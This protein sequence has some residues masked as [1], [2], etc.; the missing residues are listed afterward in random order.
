LLDA[1]LSLVPLE[2]RPVVCKSANARTRATLIF[3]VGIDGRAL[4]ITV[5]SL[6]SIFQVTQFP[7]IVNSLLHEIWDPMLSEEYRAEQRRKL[8]EFLVNYEAPV[9]MFQ[10]VQFDNHTL[11]YPFG[12]PPNPLR[13]PDLLDVIALFEPKY[14]V[15]IIV[16]LQSLEEG[17]RYALDRFPS[18]CESLRNTSEALFPRD[19]DGCNDINYR[20]RTAEDGMA[21]LTGQLQLLSREYYRVLWYDDMTGHWPDM[22]KPLQAYLK[23]MRWNAMRVMKRIKRLKVNLAQLTQGQKLF[24][25]KMVG[26]IK[27]AQ[28][29]PILQNEFDLIRFV[30]SDRS[31]AEE[32]ICV[33]G[34]LPSENFPHFQGLQH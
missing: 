29:A 15:K 33:T 5:K 19:G 20:A 25:F 3:V 17:I 6:L 32:E 31:Y 21:H 18:P 8:Q 4:R 10:M 11:A 24:L 16:A 7:D 13:R 28:W 12:S 14:D 2:K 34:P 26:A 9:D 22:G 1:R 30:A 23:L 27:T